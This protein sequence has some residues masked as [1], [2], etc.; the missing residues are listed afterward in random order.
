MR[1]RS[2]YFHLRIYHGNYSS[3]TSHFLCSPTRRRKLSCT[4]FWY[5][6]S[7]SADTDDPNEPS[8]RPPR[9]LAVVKVFDQPKVGQQAR[10][11]AE[12]QV[13]QAD[14]ATTGTLDLSV[15]QKQLLGR[16]Q[17]DLLGFHVFTSAVARFRRTG[18]ENV[19]VKELLRKLASTSLAGDK[20]V[21][22]TVVPLPAR[23]LAFRRLLL[24]AGKPSHPSLP[25]AS[26]GGVS[27]QVWAALRA[28]R[29]ERSDKGITEQ[30]YNAQSL[31]DFHCNL[32]SAGQVAAFM[33]K[34]YFRFRTG[35][36]QSI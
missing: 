17:I 14:I 11:I 27:Q 6:S 4:A 20:E 3:R 25:P 31:Q 36:K 23:K 29:L 19:D 30:E 13:M 28:L 10:Q 21:R 33:L 9:A 16:H 32:E 8:P 7:Y 1:A 24:R 22:D 35:F 18:A 26:S 2:I 12:I 34:F 5:R 15:L